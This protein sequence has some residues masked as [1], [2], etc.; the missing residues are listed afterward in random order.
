MLSRRG[1]SEPLGQGGDQ[2]GR[3][4]RFGTQR[5]HC[6][7]E[8]H[9]IPSNV[10]DPTNLDARRNAIGLQPMSDYLD[11]QQKLYGRCQPRS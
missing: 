5:G 9:A 1:L 6:D 7:G 4:Q 11:Q 2:E 3:L 10:E 8:R